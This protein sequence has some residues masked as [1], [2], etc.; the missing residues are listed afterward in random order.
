MKH[1]AK[2]FLLVLGVIAGTPVA[3]ATEIPREYRSARY[4]GMGDAGV[5][6]AEGHDALFYNPAGIADV[7]SLIN[8]VIIASPQLEL[9]SSAQD[10]YKD[11]KGGTPALQIVKGLAN[12]PQHL[13]VQNY[14]G[15]VFRRSA[16]GA[17]ERGQA[18]V[19]LG[20]DPETGMMVAKG[21]ILAHAGV[22]AAFGRDFMKNSLLLGI[23][24]KFAHKAEGNI[25]V[26]ALNAETQF[27]NTKSS[28]LMSKYVKR[29]NGV[30]A[31]L[32]GIWKFSDQSKTRLGVV[33]KNV[34][35][36]KYR[37]PVPGT[38][39]APSD[40]L[41]TVDLGVSI[42][43]GTK[44]SFSV[45]TVN[46]R[47]ATNSYK[48]SIYKRIH[49]GARISFQ[50]ILGVMAG[51]NQGYPT[52]GGFLSLKIVR[53]E[54]GVYSEEIEKNPGDLRSKRIFGR[55]SVGWTQ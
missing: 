15:L 27:K 4:L 13:A 36:M 28:S 2:K 11:Y 3:L 45:L 35:G 42:A 25:E 7:T 14:S 38:G 40:D 52:Y 33:V 8:E 26:D 46:L 23:N 47:D 19:F 1:V 30:G 43:P 5:C 34:G 41:Q 21:D 18:G 22:N 17:Y 50:N 20:T 24:L 9:S 29:G 49:L 31:D 6:L 32:G 54:A 44:K 12:E 48:E 16:L 39:I 51:L 10:I 53:V 55:V 37:W